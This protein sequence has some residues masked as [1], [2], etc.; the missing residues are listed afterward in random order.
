MICKASSQFS[1]TNN[2]KYE[3]MT[4]NKEH[5]DGAVSN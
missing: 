2:D 4:I 3:N 1:K 5:T